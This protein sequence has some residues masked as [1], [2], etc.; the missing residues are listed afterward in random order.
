MKILH[1][2]YLIFILF[3]VASSLGI[4]NYEGNILVLLLFDL[5][6][7]VIVL[8]C[9]F[10]KTYLFDLF[11]AFY[12]TMGFFLKFNV[13]LFFGGDFFNILTL[14][15]SKNEVTPPI[16]DKALL[17]SCVSF[18]AI[19]VSSLFFRYKFNLPTPPKK[20]LNIIYPFYIKHRPKI[21]LLT[22]FAVLLFNIANIR[23]GIY[24]KGGISQYNFVITYIFKYFLSFGFTFY[25]LYLLQM[26]IDRKKNFPVVFSGL[27]F[28]ENM[29][30]NISQMS[31]A[32][33]LSSMTIFIGI[34]KHCKMKKIKLSYKSIVSIIGIIILF[35]IISLHE[36]TSNRDDKFIHAR[37]PQSINIEKVNEGEFKSFLVKWSKGMLV[38]RWVGIEGIIAVSSY[39]SLSWDLF[40]SSLHEK[41]IRGLSFYD[42]NFIKSA[43]I[44]VNFS[45][46]QFVTLPGFVAYFFYPG[47]FILLS[48]FIFVT[49]SIGYLFECFSVYISNKNYII[50][51]FVSNLVAYRLINFGYMPMNT[52]QYFILILL[53]LLLYYRFIDWV[54]FKCK[55]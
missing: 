3:A 25:L 18:L 22:I 16:L 37:S 26:E 27:I 6:S 34:S 12:L 23:F 42:A 40:K 45:K 49:V 41:N 46:K 47:S 43:Y 13:L 1:I 11:I 24:S 54:Y 48:I 15:S 36:V 32:M 8:N 7:F 51:A 10:K 33:I 28:F 30:S 39:P 55:K 52:I 38:E 35:F 17:A 19:L 4:F 20:S 29:L 53:T 5:L 9:T 2:R 14:F 21:I 31:R 44:D 50:S